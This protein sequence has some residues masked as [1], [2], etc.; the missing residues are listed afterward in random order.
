MHIHIPLE[1]YWLCLHNFNLDDVHQV[2]ELS[3]STKF[4]V[5]QCAAV[6]EICE[7]NRKKEKNFETAIFNLTPFPGI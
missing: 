7:L 2:M 4:H 5:C 6:S 3:L 1:I